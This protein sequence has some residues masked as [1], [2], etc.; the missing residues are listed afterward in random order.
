MSEV[1]N[2]EKGFTLVEL[3]IVLIVIGL[4][5]SSVLVGQTLVRSAELRAATTEYQGFNAAIA[6]FKTKYNGLPGDIKG[7]T[8]FDF[9]DSAADGDGDEDGIL[10]DGSFSNYSNADVRDVHGNELV[11]FW[12][13]L[14]STGASLIP[15][16]FKGTASGPNSTDIRDFTPFSKAGGGWGVYSE[17]SINYFILG[18]VGGG[19]RGAYETKDALSG[20]DALNID[21]KIDDG[22]PNRGVVRA[23]GASTS[24]PNTDPSSSS[25]A[26][27][28]SCIIGSGVSDIDAIYNGTTDEKNC[29][30]RFKISF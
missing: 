30:L 14:G 20:T 4:I 21:E 24:D 23:R 3:S 27:D 9:G 17:S 25:A 10:T 29:T 19:S 13:H 11:F 5:V 28:T 18:V 22:K 1:K 2:M 6:T 16:V 8:K 12:N 15:G 7:F 26:N